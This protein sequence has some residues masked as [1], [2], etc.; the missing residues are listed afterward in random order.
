MF[1]ATYE[2]L[3][4][5]QALVS[6]IPCH[7]YFVIIIAGLCIQ[8]RDTY[9]IAAILNHIRATIRFLAKVAVPR[10]ATD[11]ILVLNDDKVG[12]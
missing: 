6:N 11:S 12:H 10:S 3:Q 9:P 5:F 8:A 2:D 4:Y 7:Q 1:V